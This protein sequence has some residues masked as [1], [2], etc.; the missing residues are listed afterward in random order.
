MKTIRL[1]D[2]SEWKVDDIIDK[3][4]DNEF[5]YGYLG[6]NCLSSSS[7]KKLCE[8]VEDYL[9]EDNKF[10]PN[11]KPLRD[12]RLFHVTVLETDKMDEY[13][14]FVDVSTRR[15]KEFKE[16]AST[17]KK[18]VM[19]H[20]EKLWA[21]DLKHNILKHSRSKYLIENGKPEVPNI[22]YVFGLPFR[23]KA[24]LLCEDRV[25]D[26]KTTGDIDNWDYN[27]YFYGY[28]IQ[29]YLYMKLFDKETFEFVIIDKRTKKVKTDEVT[30][31]F[32]RSGE[33]KV[34]KAVGNYV[35]YFAI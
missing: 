31:D 1:L 3:M 13:Y 34:K 27:K 30:E 22:N 19:L 24:D 4:Y 21:E 14:D 23:G 16:I 26:I 29:A 28:D 8:S 5:Y 12:G 33:H 2:G 6:A 11:L 15:N 32:L 35:K 7:C 25:V 17:S 9:F 10:S 18:E 20:K